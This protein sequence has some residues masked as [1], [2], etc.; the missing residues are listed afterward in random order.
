M[1][2]LKLTMSAFGPYAGKVVVDL[3]KLGEQGLYLITGDT[4]AGKTTLFDAITYALYG[5][6]SGGDREPSMF[7]SKYADPE[8]PTLVELV[9]SYKGKEYTV[10]RSPDYQRPSKRGGKL[11]TQPAKAELGRADGRPV[12]GVREV[13]AAI[14]SIIGLDRGQF[15][16]VAMIAQGDF[17]KLLL[18]DTKTRQEIFREIFQTRYYQTFQERLKTR[19]GKLRDECEAAQASVKQYIGGI[20]CPPESPC[21]PRTELAKRGELT[22]QETVELIETLIDN[23]RKA[24]EACEG[25]LAELDGA[26]RAVSE[27]LGKA[28]EVE[29]TRRNLAKAKQDREAQAPRVE[30]ARKKLEEQQALE[31]RQAELEGERSALEAELPRYRELTDQERTL[32]NLAGAIAAQ[33]EGQQAQRTRLTAQTES[34]AKLK[35]E[36]ET[37]AHAGEGRE[38]LLREQT[39]AESRKNALTALGRDL[40]QW[41]ACTQRLRKSKEQ[42][43]DLS[44]RQG[45][46]RKEV[47]Q[48]EAAL[49]AD[50]KAWKDTEGLEA[51]REKGNARRTQAQERA[52]GLQALEGFLHDCDAAR[53]ALKQAQNAYQTAADAL[54][55]AEQDYRQKDRAFLDEQAGV[56]AQHLRP[57]E[58]C[59]VCGSVEHP[60]P[61]RMSQ[62]APTEAQL[63][64]AKEAVDVARAKANQ[65]SLKA[66]S[67]KTALEEREKKLLDGM[68]D[69]VEVP[70]IEE[71]PAQIAACQ[72][73]NEQT[74]AQLR[75][76]AKALETKLMARQALGEHIAAQEQ[77]LKAAKERQERLDQQLQQAQVDHSALKGQQ[78]QLEGK[79]V[80]Q[81]GEQLPGVALAEAPKALADQRAQVEAQLRTL[82]AQLD[83]VQKQLQRK[84][85]LETLIPRREGELRDLENA[86]SKA[87]ADLAGAES[88][89]TALTEQLAALKASLR[90]P[91][92]AAAER[93]VNTLRQEA[94][95]LKQA[96]KTAEEALNRE[97]TAL[98]QLDAAIAQLTGL[99]RDGEGTDIEA[100]RTRSVELTGRRA[101]VEGE[102]RS[103]HTRL[104]TNQT[105]L[106][107]I[108]ARSADLT[109][110]EAQYTWV[111][112]LSNT[113]N[114]NL[115][116]KG[117]VDLET[118]V[119][120]TRFDSIIQRANSRLMVMSGGQYDLRRRTE[121]ENNRSKSGLELDVIDH[122]N[123]SERSVKSLSGGES[124]QASLSLAL[125][126]SDEIQSSAHGISLDTMFVDEGFGSLDEEA[127]QQAI[128]ALTGLTEGKRLVGII[129][130]VAELKE[131]IDKQIVVTKDR[132]GGSRVEIVV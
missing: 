129:S 102:R 109:R 27:R 100:E 87:Q 101:Q 22:F 107:N 42:W 39:Q 37:L 3:E 59:P 32:A 15:A 89:K 86:I 94:E 85:E 8:T 104:T 53:S 67:C 25:Q 74:M 41:Q 40:E 97:N 126:L 105:A 110:L 96:R 56:L 98:A 57:G 44:A 82:A 50:Q 19:T 34:L 81:L 91:D 36:G 106:S 84:E 76:E 23:D 62:N 122:Y 99:L 132:T 6:P 127:L 24:E 51:E 108:Q 79:L 130:H 95:G 113:V 68:K 77:A 49:Q 31:P 28:E 128:R 54:E 26:I 48:K 92:A 12:A 75:Q 29:K 2:P 17:R 88:R 63:Q 125:G 121:A 131:K 4:G 21:A 115:T 30:L 14:R 71:A 18:A 45:S 64:R 20:L 72:K 60:A 69:Y 119:Q 46:F 55:A 7:R 114:G 93:R 80:Q 120:M 10:R 16:Q 78:E 1:R 112:T 90:Y 33:Q 11:V 43:E 61:A 38:R 70:S 83:A 124:F 123:G 117:K 5:E 66:G 35:A 111:R 58:P 47:E 103:L 73:E 118:Y 116:G 65:A 52:R 13:N 9:F